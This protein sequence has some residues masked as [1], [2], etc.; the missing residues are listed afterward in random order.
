MSIW[1]LTREINE[2]D[3]DGEYFVDA[4]LEK[5]THEILSASKVPTN[6]L[7]HVLNGG[8]RI[9]FENEWFHLKEKND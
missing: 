4:W 5:P 3:Q 1:I 9:G 8:G 7:R 6:R 2:Y